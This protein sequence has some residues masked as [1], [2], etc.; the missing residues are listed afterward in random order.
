[1][2]AQLRRRETFRRSKPFISVSGGAKLALMALDPAVSSRYAS[3]TGALAGRV[4]TSRLLLTRFPR[5]GRGGCRR[6]HRTDRSPPAGIDRGKVHARLISLGAEW[7]RL[8]RWQWVRVAAAGIATAAAAA[9]LSLNGIVTV[10][11]ATWCNALIV[12]VGAL[13]KGLVAG[14]YSGIRC[15]RAQ[16]PPPRRPRILH[17]PRS[18]HHA[19]QRQCC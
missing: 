19:T 2:I 14:S 18:I 9:P 17:A 16:R 7:R 8:P 5:D 6:L 3:S 13:L 4:V 15:R 1:M 11:V 12:A 10:T